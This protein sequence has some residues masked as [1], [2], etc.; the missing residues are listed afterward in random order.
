MAL[1]TASRNARAVLAAAGLE[2][3]FDVVVDG[4]TAAQLGLAGKPDPALFLHAIRELG[5]A[6]ERAVVI[7]DA[8]AGVAAGRRGGFGLVVGIDRAGHRAEL[9]AAGADVVVEDV[10]ELDLG[11]VIADPWQ[12]VYEGFDPAHEGHREALTTLGNGY[13]ATRERPLNTARTM[14][15][16]REPTWPASTTGSPA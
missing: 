14:C 13:M 11:L 1:A 8:V 7:E 6:P 10:S 16:I 3:G 9:E 15:T 12:L 2:D 4:N 5:V